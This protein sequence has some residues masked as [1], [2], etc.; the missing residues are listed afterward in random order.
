MRFFALIQNEIIK[1]NSKRQSI[2]FLY[3]CFLFIVA[4]G[5]SNKILPDLRTGLDGLKFAK[6]TL[7]ILTVFVTLFAIVLGSQSI[8]D[9]YRDGTIKQLLMRPV[10]RTTILL[11][12]YTANLLMI[13]FV[14]LFIYVISIVIGALLF[15]ISSTGSLTLWTTAKL[16]LYNLPDAFFMMTLSFFIATIWKSRTFIKQETRRL[17]PPGSCLFLLIFPHS[18]IVNQ[19]RIGIIT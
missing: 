7:S 17:L 11:S 14:M 5:I 19:R 4:I 12:K 10:S 16:C 6:N 2:L 18:L 13:G 1:I 15:G 9:E 8:T 3:F